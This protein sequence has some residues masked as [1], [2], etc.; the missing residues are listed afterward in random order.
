MYS[1][2]VHAHSHYNSCE[3]V[4]VDAKVTAGAPSGPGGTDKNLDLEVR[5]EEFEVKEMYPVYLDVARN[6]RER[7]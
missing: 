7:S 1:E 2:Q 6:G 5:G 4:N 3:D